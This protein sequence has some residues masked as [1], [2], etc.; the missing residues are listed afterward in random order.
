MESQRLSQVFFSN[1][2]NHLV[3]FKISLSGRNRTRERTKKLKEKSGIF[4]REKILEIEAIRGILAEFALVPLALS[5][6][7]SVFGPKVG[8]RG[9]LRSLRSFIIF[10]IKAH[11]FNV[12]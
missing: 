10:I 12:K 8:R 1:T 5:L 3:S 7:D 2:K 9:T 11:A 4:F 6:Q